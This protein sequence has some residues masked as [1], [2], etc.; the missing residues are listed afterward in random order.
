MVNIV[1][2]VIKEVEPLEDAV[3]IEGLP[4][5]GHVGRIVAEHI[6][7]EFNGEKVLEL[8]C[9]DFPPQV[10][11]NEDGTV[12]FMN[13]SIYIIK[14]PI[15]II[16]VTGNTQALTPMGQYQTSKRLTELGIKY[17]A[18]VVYTIGGF[19]IGNLKENPA[20]YVA[21]TSKELANKIKGHGAVFRGDGGGI[22]G[23]AGLML[24]FSKLNGIDGACIMGETPGYL[25]DPKSAGRVLEVLSKILGIEIN[26]DEIEKRAKEMEM[27]LE[28][29]RNFEKSQEQKQAMPRDDDLRYI[30]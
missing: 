28:K 25:I 11:V 30:G 15:P 5:I 10:L 8:Y 2:K 18:R 19:G 13:N 20:V 3:L 12:E 21:A 16:V 6:I 14:E 9:D 7:H 22:L 1:E 24:T 26:M 29:I 4:G 23:A 17:G 27:F